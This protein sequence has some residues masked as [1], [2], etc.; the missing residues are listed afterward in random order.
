MNKSTVAPLGIP[1]KSESHQPVRSPIRA[2]L[3]DIGGTLVQ[4]Q[5]HASRSR[6]ILSEL[7]DFLD[8]DCSPEEMAAKLTLRENDYKNW[9]DQSLTELSY[10]ER[11]V[12]FFLPEYPSD[13]VRQNAEQLQAWWRKSRGKRWITPE[14]VQTL[15]ELIDRG[16]LLGTVSH[17]SIRYL[18]DA[19]IRDLFKTSIQAAAFGMRKPHPSPFLAAAREMGVSPA[20]CAYIGDRPSRDI[21]GPREAGFGQIILLKQAGHQTE[22][23]PCPMQ[24]D[25]IIRAIPELLDYFPRLEEDLQYPAQPAQFPVLYDAALSTMWWSKDRDTAEDFCVKARQLG[26]AR[27]ELNHQIPPSDL[28]S[29]DLTRY[30]IGSLHDPCPAVVPNKQIEREDRLVTSLDENLRRSGVDIVKRTI[31]QAYQLCARSVIIHPGRITGDHSPDDQLRV[32]FR[33]GLKGSAEYEALRLLAIADR[34]K[35]STPHLEA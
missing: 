27:F 11:W 33:Q 25:I 21:V 19:G 8:A 29:F 7:V 32:L 16:Y 23:I 17:S 26:F 31:D 34:K 24:A 10:E 28:S 35:R 5:N 9:R 6:E 2:I 18:D 13:F 3:F 20:E 12:R 15:R 4:K 1:L 14:T 30:H 22:E